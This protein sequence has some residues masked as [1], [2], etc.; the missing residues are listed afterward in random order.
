M[1]IGLENNKNKIFFENKNKNS[2]KIQQMENEIKIME[3]VKFQKKTEFFQE[4]QRKKKLGVDFQWTKKRSIS[5]LNDL[6]EYLERQSYAKQ[7]ISKLEND[8]NL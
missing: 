5:L 4:F 1:I 2:E 8:L 6:E 7:N 3:R